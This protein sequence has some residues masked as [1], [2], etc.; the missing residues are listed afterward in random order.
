[1]KKVIK[2]TG[3]NTEKL[4]HNL[5]RETHLARSAKTVQKPAGTRQTAHEGV[6]V[7]GWK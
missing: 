1:M 3:T 5:R 6:L 2:G 4:N 7:G